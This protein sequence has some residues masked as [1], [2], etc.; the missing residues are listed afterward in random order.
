MKIEPTDDA[1]R[2]DDGS[3]EE[4][5]AMAISLNGRAGSETTDQLSDKGQRG[6]ERRVQRVDGVGLRLCVVCA[7]LPDEALR[8][9]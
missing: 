4:E 2:G 6:E 3:D 5:N 9:E 8:Y 1:D 7:E